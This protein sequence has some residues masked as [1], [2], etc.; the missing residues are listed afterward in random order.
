MCCVMHA[1][2]NSKAIDYSAAKGFHPAVQRC[3]SNRTFTR[4]GWPAWVEINKQPTALLCKLLIFFIH[5]PP[6]RRFGSFFNAICDPFAS[7]T[8]AR[9]HLLWGKKKSFEIDS[10]CE[11]R[12][13]SVKNN[14]WWTA[15]RWE[16]GAIFIT[17]LQKKKKKGFTSA[18]RCVSD[19]WT[20][21]LLSH[22]DAVCLSLSMWSFFFPHR[23]WR[24][25]GRNWSRVKARH[26]V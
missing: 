4:A 12:Q 5:P 16:R 26:C 6:L 1:Q 10:V 19:T 8:A 9:Q 20:S 3:I 17:A 2:Y 15:V 22:L 18:E 23:I 21:A 24:L 11:P 13:P 7:L 25:C 14:S